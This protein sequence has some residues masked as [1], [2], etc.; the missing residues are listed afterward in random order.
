[1]DELKWYGIIGSALAYFFFFLREVKEIFFDHNNG[2]TF[3]NK[4]KKAFLLSKARKKKI[5]EP[6]TVEYTDSERKVVTDN[7][8]MH[9]FFIRISKLK[10]ELQN[11][12]FDGSV[13]K[14]LVLREVISI[15]LDILEKHASD[16]IKNSKFDEYS[17]NELNEKLKTEI[18]LT[19]YEIYA[20]LRERLGDTIYNK[21]IED[22]VKG[23]KARNGFLKEILLD[24]VLSISSQS[25][26]VYNYDNYKR[27]SEVLTS[28]YISI[29]VIVKNFE[30]VF[31]D[32]N[33]EL[34][35]L[36]EEYK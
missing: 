30:K 26:S 32:F 5:L 25:M 6:K 27:A 12:D 18:A 19:T 14:N 36:L 23:F 34:E 7:L 10:N 29:Q 9:N 22:P 20:K 17:T 11:I 4:L 2:E 33:G 15:Y 31:K 8:L 28:M 16:F 1:M 13:K 21:V 3:L 35:K 24:G